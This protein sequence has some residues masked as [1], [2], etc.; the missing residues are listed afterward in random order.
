M[1]QRNNGKKESDILQNRFTAYLSKAVQHRRNDYLEQISRCREESMPEEMIVELG[2]SMEQDIMEGLPLMIRLED[3]TLF[4]ALKSLS[5]KERHV[6][7]ARVL[8]EKGFDVL[9]VELGQGYKGVA[10]V[11]YRAVEK[12]KKKIKEAGKNGF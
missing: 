6:F 9:A 11:Y 2:G 5:E 8:D 7:L 10:A 3:N 4:Y 1:R 12:L